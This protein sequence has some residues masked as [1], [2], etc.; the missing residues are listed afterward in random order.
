MTTTVGFIGS[1]NIGGT[2]A[3]L[4]IEAGYQRHDHEQAAAATVHAILRDA[5]FDLGGEVST[6]RPLL[7]KMLTA[8]PWPEDVRLSEGDLGGIPTT[9]VSIAGA[10]TAGVILHLHGGGFAVGSA[11]G[12]VGLAS[13]VAR[14]TAELLLS[15]KQE[16]IEMPCA[17]ALD[18]AAGQGI[19]TILP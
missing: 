10:E 7:E 18:R 1:G 2:L 5:P 12:S 9:F 6:Q 15:L 17:A 11:R 14:R 16:G 3:R 13:A 4:A 19:G 8:Q